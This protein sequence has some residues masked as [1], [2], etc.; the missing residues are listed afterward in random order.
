MPGMFHD[1]RSFAAATVAFLLATP[2]FAQSSLD[3][4]LN[5]LL[6][7]K[8]VQGALVG[9]DIMEVGP[10]GPVPIFAHQAEALL[11]PAS[12]QKLLTT[13][14]AFMKYGPKATFKTQVSRA[15]EDLVLVGSGDPGLGDVKLGAEHGETLTNAFDV[16]AQQLKQKGITRLHDLWVDD[17]IFDTQWVHPEW[18]TD[19]LLSWYE[20]PVGGLNF[21]ANCLDWIPKVFREGVGAE[22]VPPT[23]YVTIVNRAR[24]GGEQ[25]VWMWRAPETNKFELRG[26]IANSAS[27]PE[28]V[29]IYDPGLWTG[30]VLRDRLVTAGITITGRV[31]RVEAGADL[32][33]EVLLTAET[34]LLGI[35][36]R[37]NKNSV[38]M[39]AEGLCKRLGHDASDGKDPG[40]WENGTAAVTAFARG[41]GV[42]PELLKLRDG[43]GLSPENRV[44]ARAITMVLAN[45]AG[46]REGEAFVATLAVPGEDGT[47]Q[48]RFRGMP[49]VAKGV[50]GKTGHING[51]SALSGYLDVNRRRFAFSILVNKSKSP[52]EM[53]AWEEKVV[54]QVWEWAGGE[55][56][57]GE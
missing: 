2:L 41:L 30:T 51:V 10:Q 45:V 43:S 56:K 12:C 20:A 13:G 9:L 5:D 14:A 1:R 36:R 21:N 37:A 16:W 27:A 49:A 26:T 31:R 8:E 4:R 34:P 53:N 57:K 48:R 19:Q 11:T 33:A 55:S 40:T 25:K 18:P 7:R 23:T 17:R 24:R 32:K 42:G 47:L 50:H 52:W 35:L 15:G 44:A 46:S 54:Q 22:L 3:A 38:N 29:T 6:A 39:M 28:S